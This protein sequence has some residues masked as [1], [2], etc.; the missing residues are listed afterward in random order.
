MKSDPAAE[1]CAAPDL[2]PAERHEAA[3]LLARLLTE[4]QPSLDEV[5]DDWRRIV[6]LTIRTERVKPE[7]AIALLLRT[8]ADARRL[9]ASIMSIVSAMSRVD[10][11]DVCWQPEQPTMDGAKPPGEGR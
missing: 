11:D 6:L 3:D 4:A 2:V 9:C 10:R 7:E 1:L 8:A 5:S